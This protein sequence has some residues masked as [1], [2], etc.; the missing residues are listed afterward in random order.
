M[1]Y[2][3]RDPRVDHLATLLGR[4]AWLERVLAERGPNHWHSAE[5]SALEWALRTLQDA[6]SELSPLVETAEQIAEAR[7][8]KAP[9]PGAA[10]DGA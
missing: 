8:A 4:R 6:D 1:R 9:L 7:L 3:N 2:A 5:V 10:R